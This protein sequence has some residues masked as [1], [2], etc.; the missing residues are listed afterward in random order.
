MPTNV[1]G[2]DIKTGR[3]KPENIIH[4]ENE[5]PFC[6]P[7]G[8]TGII[9]RKNDI[10]F[11]KNKFPVLDSADHF[12][13]VECRDCGIDMPDYTPEYMHTLIDFGIRQ[14]F[15]LI[16]SKR[17]ASVLF[18]KNHGPLSGGTMRHAHMQLVGLNNINPA[19]LYEPEGFNGIKIDCRNNI[20]LNAAT[21]PRLGFSEFNIVDNNNEN[22]DTIADYIQT[23]LKY[24]RLYQ[25]NSNESYN[26]F[27]YLIDGKIKV[28]LLPRFATSP[29]F[30]GYDIRILPSNIYDSVKKMQALLAK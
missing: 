17:Y 2:F 9:E 27:F 11:L 15:R 5:C 26:I 16:D 21:N 13:L 4:S 8:L 3:S 29:L 18:F 19:L 28:K 7:E 24:F 25:P 6:H 10:I 12:V 23:V 1:I 30:V 20:L 14:W 22:T